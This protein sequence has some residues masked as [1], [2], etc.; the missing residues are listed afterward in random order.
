MD[1][2]HNIAAIDSNNEDNDDKEEGRRW[3]RQLGDEHGEND[4]GCLGGT[5]DNPWNTDGDS[6]VKN[7][8][9]LVTTATGNEDRRLGPSG[10]G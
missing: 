9:T 3:G 7:D 2:N 6:A 5:R 1:Q 8:V 4:D 10:P